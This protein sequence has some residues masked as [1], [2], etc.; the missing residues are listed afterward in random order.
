M[1]YSVIPLLGLLVRPG[2]KKKIH[3]TKISLS[4]AA[5]QTFLERLRIQASAWRK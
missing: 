3:M 2:A 5:M 1:R 4:S